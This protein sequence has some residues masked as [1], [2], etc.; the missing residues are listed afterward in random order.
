MRGPTFIALHELFDRVVEHAAD[1]ADLLAERVVQLGATD[2]LLWFVEAPSH[3]RSWAEPDPSG[4]VSR[5]T[6]GLRASESGPATGP[7]VRSAHAGRVTTP[8]CG[9]V[10]GSRQVL[11]AE[12]PPA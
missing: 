11:I 12:P 9:P 7:A 10:P 1:A 4:P 2:K 5:P 8:P 6:G 3:A